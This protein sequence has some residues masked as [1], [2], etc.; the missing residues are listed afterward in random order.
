M[1]KYL[2]AV[3]L[4][5]KIMSLCFSYVDEMDSI[6]CN[7]KIDADSNEEA[8]SFSIHRSISGGVPSHYE[9]EVRVTRKLKSVED[10]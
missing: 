2:T 3:N 9:Y 10:E 4:A 8:C 1:N 5:E 6:D 7:P